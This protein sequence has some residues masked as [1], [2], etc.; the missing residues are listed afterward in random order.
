MKHK[1]CCA[2]E[3]GGARRREPAGGAT[4]L[5]RRAKAHAL[6]LIQLFSQACGVGESVRMCSCLL[7]ALHSKNTESGGLVHVSNRSRTDSFG[8]RGAT[9]ARG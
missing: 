8:E 7:P 6:P 1:L 2:H 4:R 3:Q 5:S 9:P